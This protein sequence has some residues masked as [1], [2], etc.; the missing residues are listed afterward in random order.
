MDVLASQFLADLA[1]HQP[2]P[3]EWQQDQIRK[4]LDVFARDVD[5]WRFERDDTARP[6][7]VPLGTPPHG[8]ELLVA[9]AVCRRALD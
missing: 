2:P 9:G 8:Q 5:H 3:S 6:K 7:C 4:A 1:V